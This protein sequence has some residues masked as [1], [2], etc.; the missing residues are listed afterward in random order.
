M[1]GITYK[2]TGAEETRRSVA[3]IRLDA[4]QN[5]VAS[6][7]DDMASEAGT[8]PA[9]PPGSGYQRTNDLHDGWLDSEPVFQIDSDTLLA[10]LTNPVPYGGYVQGA[11]DQAEVHQGRWRT[12][13]ALMDAWE[14]KAT[15]RLE[16]ALMQQ[17]GM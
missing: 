15:E 16:D 7:L 5:T 17:V 6:I 11:E 1:I 13:E 14:E 2:I 4:L 12:V 8:Y 3:K 9:P 10:T